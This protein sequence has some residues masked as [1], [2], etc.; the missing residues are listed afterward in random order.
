MVCK[1]IVTPWKTRY[2]FSLPAGTR[3]IRLFPGKQTKNHIT[4]RNLT[5]VRNLVFRNSER[6]PGTRVLI[7]VRDIV[8]AGNGFEVTGSQPELEIAPGFITASKPDIRL[9]SLYGLLFL[10]C[11]SILLG[12]SAD[13][14]N[15][16]GEQAVRLL[17]N[18]KNYCRN[19]RWF[20]AYAS[21]CLIILFGYELFN[22]PITADDDW[23]LLSQFEQFENSMP[24]A[25]ST[26]TYHSLV[27][28]L[29]AH[30]RWSA[31]V[32]HGIFTGYCPVIS[33]LWSLVCISV[34]FLL[35][36]ERLSLPP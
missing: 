20:L 21:V 32:E 4:I 23:Y 15:H 14:W 6:D 11:S 7:P 26:L 33:L 3:R 35:L 28:N 30:G 27:D 2:D 19:N 8:A 9:I 22:S 31:A 36:A 5:L 13:D 18:L 17:E 1:E 10:L 34:I 25:Y 24:G 29:I 16:R 12:A